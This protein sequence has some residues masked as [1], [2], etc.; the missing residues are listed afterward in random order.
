MLQAEGAA[1]P[2]S[3]SFA[4]PVL[5]RAGRQV[6]LVPKQRPLQTFLLPHRTPSSTPHQPQSSCGNIPVSAR[7]TPTHPSKPSLSVT[8]SQQP[9]LT[10]LSVNSPLCILDTLLIY[11][12]NA[13]SLK[14]YLPSRSGERRRVPCLGQSRQRRWMDEQMKSE[15]VPGGG[16]PSAPCP[17]STPQGP[18]VDQSQAGCQHLGLPPTSTN[19]LGGLWTNGCVCLSQV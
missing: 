12:A 16:N 8:A 18:G 14:G 10:S 6:A 7:Q 11:T 1:S 5:G 17:P 13:A 15:G 19:S 3:R 4:W 9:S 2:R